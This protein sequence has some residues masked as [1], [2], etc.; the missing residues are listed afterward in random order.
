MVKIDGVQTSKIRRVAVVTRAAP[1]VTA[2]P[3][4]RVYTD[5]STLTI[6][7]HG[8]DYVADQNIVTF[9]AQGGGLVSGTVTQATISHLVVSLSSIAPVN[10]DFQTG[11][12]SASV[13]IDGLLVGGVHQYVSASVE[14]AQVVAVPPTLAASDAVRFGRT[15]RR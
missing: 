9:A 3:M 11:R 5:A 14:V 8:F 4:T 6:A 10:Q 1:V 7:G 13:T 2:S 12:L 15:P